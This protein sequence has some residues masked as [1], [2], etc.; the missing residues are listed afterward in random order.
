MKKR[1]NK[2]QRYL[3]THFTQEEFDSILDTFFSDL[4]FSQ[5]IGMAAH[6]VIGGDFSVSALLALGLAIFRSLFKAIRVGFSKKE[7]K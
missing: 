7:E 2:F 3:K 1:L 5:A 6:N 4:I